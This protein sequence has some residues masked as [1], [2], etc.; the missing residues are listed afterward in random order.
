MASSSLHQVGAG[1]MGSGGLRRL[2]TILRER[3]WLI[4]LCILLGGA[5]AAAYVFY[6]PKSYAARS[7]IQYQNTIAYW[8]ALADRQPLDPTRQIA[9]IR[10]RLEDPE[11]LRRIVVGQRLGENPRFGKGQSGEA[12]ITRAVQILNRRLHVET[13]ATGTSLDIIVTDLSPELAAR[14]ANATVDELLAEYSR[15]RAELLEE[16]ST[17]LQK[18]QDEIWK[19]LRSVSP[20]SVSDTNQA[21]GSLQARR[22]ELQEKLRT[23]TTQLV[24]ADLRRLELTS[25]LDQAQDLADQ[26]LTALQVPYIAGL[27]N[28]QSARSVLLQKQVEL[29]R[30]SERYKGKHPDYLAALDARVTGLGHRV[31]RELVDLGRR[32]AVDGRPGR[33]RRHVARGGILAPKHAVHLLGWR[34]L[35]AGE[36]HDPRKHVPQGL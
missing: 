13:P 12:A 6:A 17:L 16:I 7:T 9:E 22:Q 35:V 19:E 10:A 25:Q 24:E 8:L 28:V 14:I 21:A 33:R 3:A 4:L 18:R 20:A 27:P 5:A 36:H 26:P 31:Q 34:R 32:G 29:E 23:L 15:M 1:G 11:L 30:T 2:A